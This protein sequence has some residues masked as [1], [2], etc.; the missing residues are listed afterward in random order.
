MLATLVRQ[1]YQGSILLLVPVTHCLGP[2]PHLPAP[3]CRLGHPPQVW[4]G[5]WVPTP[6]RPL[7]TKLWI[8][9][10][11][12]CWCSR[13][14]TV[15]FRQNLKTVWVK[16]SIHIYI[17]V[18]KQ[19]KHWDC[20]SRLRRHWE[21]TLHLPCTQPSQQ[22]LPI[23]ITAVFFSFTELG[24]GWAELRHAFLIHNSWNNTEPERRETKTFYTRI[25]WLTVSQTYLDHES[26]GPNTAL[27]CFFDQS[28]M[29]TEV[30][31]VCVCVWAREQVTGRFRRKNQ[32]IWLEKSC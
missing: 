4:R 29:H 7:Q 24:C 21:Q 28:Q 2:V 27:F 15:L 20:F 31:D 8:L 1:A 13:A 3:T 17:H 30:K 19:K 23:H 10:V 6:P 5:R 32:V 16:I 12:F 18:T 11:T 26:P 22:W 14:H 9:V 25:C